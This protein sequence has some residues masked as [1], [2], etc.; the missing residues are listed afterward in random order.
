[1]RLEKANIRPHTLRARMKD[2][3]MQKAIFTAGR[4]GNSIVVTETRF[5]YITDDPREILLSK[6]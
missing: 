5:D 6:G 2:K 1:M 4:I 3:G